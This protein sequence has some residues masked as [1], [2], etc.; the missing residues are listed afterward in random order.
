MILGYIPSAPYLCF[1]TSPTFSGA[2]AQEKGKSSSMEQQFIVGVPREGGEGLVVSP[3]RP[4][5][6]ALAGV[7]DRG[8]VNRREVL[9]PGFFGP[10]NSVPFRGDHFPPYP[11]PEKGGGSGGCRTGG[12]GGGGG[13]A[14]DFRGGQVDGYMWEGRMT[15]G[16]EQR[17]CALPF[18]GDV[19][20][21]ER[22]IPDPRRRVS[23]ARRF[24]MGDGGAGGRKDSVWIDPVYLLKFEI[25]GAKEPFTLEDFVAFSDTFPDLP[26]D[27][28][29]EFDET[30]DHVI[31][32]DPADHRV[33]MFALPRVSPATSSPPCAPEQAAPPSLRRRCKEGKKW[34]MLEQKVSCTTCHQPIVTLLL[35]GTR[36]DLASEHAI[37]IVCTSC[38]ENGFEAT[39]FLSAS[40]SPVAAPD[41]DGD[42]C[43][44][45][46]KRKRLIGFGG[47]RLVGTDVRDGDKEDGNR[48][49]R[50]ETRS[51][52][53]KPLFLVESVCQ[54][55]MKKHR[56]C[57]EC[58][59]GGKF[60]TGKWRPKEVF[61]AGRK[62]CKLSH[63]RIGKARLFYSD[64]IQIE[65]AIPRLGVIVPVSEGDCWASRRVQG[66]PD[67][68]SGLQIPNT[69]KDFISA[70]LS[71]RPPGSRRRYV[72][73][74]WAIH[75]R[76]RKRPKDGKGTRRHKSSDPTGNA[77]PPSDPD[78]R[79]TRLLAGMQL[80]EWN[81]EGR[82]F[83]LGI[84]CVNGTPDLAFDICART[85]A[86][87]RADA[88]DIGLLPIDA[89]PD[90]DASATTRNWLAAPPVIH[91]FVSTRKLS[92]DERGP[93]RYL[94]NP[95]PIWSRPRAK[96]YPRL[97]ATTRLGFV[98][99]A[100][101]PPPSNP[102]TMPPR[103]G[104]PSPVKVSHH[105]GKTSTRDM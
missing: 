52:W 80:A 29:V 96:P 77:R 49:E 37:Q 32:P 59:G 35:H 75:S 42:V 9:D 100:N 95:P 24:A 18:G 104:S 12:S 15:G 34:I 13:V 105:S 7:A 84:S 54:A 101:T 6:R 11:D 22:K 17:Q 79:P 31:S 5:I 26:S 10:G 43:S 44:P 81:P 92:P 58:G 89:E 14:F 56:F 36:E 86:R 82:T 8:G 19:G 83:T 93:A 57:S 28:P 68:E 45:G 97:A 41:R 2:Q 38:L 103:N 25:R 39:F 65:Y 88:I 55:C 50:V 30:F 91:I 78:S 64:Y 53:V 1:F 51:P 20:P 99:N 72:G 73:L 61:E 66:P 76:I 16:V 71:T 85:L 40:T 62:T 94:A 87:L 23:E 70:Y 47:V 21:S 74:A 4:T 98:P 90:A 48:V 3:E 33:D 63:Q 102:P 67:V 27:D 69:A 60:R 46:R